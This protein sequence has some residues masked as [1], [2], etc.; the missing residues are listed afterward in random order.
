M[1]KASK[2]RNRVRKPARAPGLPV[3]KWPLRKGRRVWFLSSAATEPA[4]YSGWI[5]GYRPDVLHDGENSRADY[6]IRGTDCDR[7]FVAPETNVRSFNNTGKAEL[8]EMLI[9]WTKTDVDSY[10]TSL[11]QARTRLAEYD[12][13]LAVCRPPVKK[14]KKGKP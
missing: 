7:N 4:L 14:T 1:K 10:E 8:L 12:S 2:R 11:K 3:S 9:R 6:S 13:Q 5:T